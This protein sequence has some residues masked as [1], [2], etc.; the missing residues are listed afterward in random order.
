MDRARS[1]CPTDSYVP[2]LAYAI[3]DRADSLPRMDEH[4][5]VW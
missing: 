3:A 1:L 2:E 5:P 4:A